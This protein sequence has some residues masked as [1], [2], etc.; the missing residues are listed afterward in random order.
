MIDKLFAQQFAK[1]W[2]TGW[3][4]HDI[5]QVLA[6]YSDDFEMTSPM[7]IQFAN[8]QS[9]VLSGKAAIMNYWTQALQAM[10]QLHFTLLNVLTGVNTITLYYQGVNGLVAEVFHF[11]NE[12]KVIKA[13]AH[14]Q[15]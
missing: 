11:N 6:H 1:E 8:Q 3:N 2:I 4:N 12:Q 5:A 13:Y 7:I 15:S 9:G 14:Y 10:P